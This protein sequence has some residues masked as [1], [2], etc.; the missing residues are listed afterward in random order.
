MPA[1]HRRHQEWTPGRII[2]WAEKTGPATAQL[3]QGILESRPH[4]EQGFRSCLGILRLS[5]RYGADRVEAACQR[6]LAVRAFSYRS[7][8]S[9]LKTGLDRQP[10]PAPRPL[11][12]H[13]RHDN[14]R[15]AGYYQ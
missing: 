7:L 2:S 15:G 13:R 9:I 6:A 14:L 3:T 12:T 4:P 5:D 11:R 1:S 10:L 8:E